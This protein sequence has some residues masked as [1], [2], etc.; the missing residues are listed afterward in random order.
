MCMALA[1]TFWPLEFQGNV[2]SCSGGDGERTARDRACGVGV[3]WLS[4]WEVEAG[5]VSTTGSEL[6]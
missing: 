6:S 2:K 3:H 1:R 5:T 4:D